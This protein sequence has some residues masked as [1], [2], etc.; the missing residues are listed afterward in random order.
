MRRRRPPSVWV[1][2]CALGLV[3]AVQ[4]VLAIRFGRAADLGPFTSAFAVILWTLLLAGLLRGARLAWLW[5]RYL[6]PILAV[7]I[8]SALAVA[9]VRGGTRLAVVALAFA[10][11]VLPLAVASVALGRRSAY[12]YFDLVCPACATRS[13]FGADFLFRQ[14]RCRKCDTVW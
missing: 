8:A 12:G 7:V 6:T 14:A 9:A 13:G 11:L 10:G 2:T 1:A 5:G 4:V 3:V